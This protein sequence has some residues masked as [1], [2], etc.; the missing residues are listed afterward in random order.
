MTEHVGSQEVQ[1]VIFSLGGEEYCVDI[2]CVREIIR[3][4][5][6]TRIPKLP[7]FVEGV[8]NLRGQITTVIDMRKRFEMEP[9]ENDAN[10][11]I[12]IDL[13]GEPFGAVVD[14]VYEVKTISLD[15]IVS[16]PSIKHAQTQ[17]YLK[18]ICK[19]DDRILI[20]LDFEK[21]LSDLELA[22]TIKIKEEMETVN[23]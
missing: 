8:I 10:R 20:L 17:E 19:I 12:I 7:D 9:L 16:V 1:V 5:E 4:V 13:Q 23:T 18:G 6:I 3:M 21:I 14:S 15:M 22:Q 2:S 11:I